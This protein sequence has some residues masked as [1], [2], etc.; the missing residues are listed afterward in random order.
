MHREYAA[1]GSCG[2]HTAVIP[3]GPRTRTRDPHPGP[4]RPGSPRAAH[5]RPTAPYGKQSCRCTCKQFTGLRFVAVG[6]RTGA[7]SQVPSASPRASPL[8]KK[9]AVV[10]GLALSPK[11]LRLTSQRTRQN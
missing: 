6:V 5:V 4:P 2:E 7:E 1:L 3:P 10:Y 9:V 11:W 8:G